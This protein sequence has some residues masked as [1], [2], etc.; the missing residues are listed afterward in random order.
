MNRRNST[1]LANIWHE[2]EHKEGR[3]HPDLNPG[4]AN[5]QPAALTTELCALQQAPARFSDAWCLEARVE[6]AVFAFSP[7]DLQF[8]VFLQTKGRAQHWE[9]RR[10]HY[11][12]RWFATQ[13]ASQEP[14]ARSRE[15]LAGGRADS[16]E[17]SQH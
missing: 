15:Y 13:P 1:A 7:A 5:L 17:S 12:P 4:P 6:D 2:A 10:F 16:E 8:R 3:A 11:R 9:V 14:R